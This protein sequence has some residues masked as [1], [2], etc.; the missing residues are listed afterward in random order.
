MGAVE[1]EL[2]RVARRSELTYRVLS[3]PALRWLNRFMVLLWRLGL[4]RTLN[5]TPWATGRYMIV[6]TTGRR[7][8]RTRRTSVN[9]AP[10]DGDVCCVAAWGP[11]SNWFRNLVAD[12]TV[13]VWLPGGRW[14]GHAEP[15]ADRQ[16]GAAAMRTLLESTGALAEV[17]AGIDPGSISDEAVVTLTSWWPPVRIRLLEPVRGPGGPSDLVWVWPAAALAFLILRSRRAKRSCR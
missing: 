13:E 15:I 2:E 3:P 6:T 12:P 16:E 7:T 1:R 5:A 4:G 11:R 17:L 10:L 9:Y 8:G 14:A